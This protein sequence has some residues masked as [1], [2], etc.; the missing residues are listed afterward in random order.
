MDT[1]ALLWSNKKQAGEDGLLLLSTEISKVESVGPHFFERDT[2]S[3]RLSS[4]VTAQARD[5]RS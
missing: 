1:V 4:G 2:R 3:S 5:V